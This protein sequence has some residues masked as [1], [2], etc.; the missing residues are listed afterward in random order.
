MKRKI[1]F[2]LVFYLLIISG[3]GEMVKAATKENSFE[4]G[5][6]EIGYKTC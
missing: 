4:K 1:C 6:F 3:Y 2:I 5:L